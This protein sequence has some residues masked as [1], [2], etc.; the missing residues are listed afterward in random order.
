MNQPCCC[1]RSN[2]SFICFHL[3]VKLTRENNDFKGTNSN[4]QKLVV[5]LEKDLHK[6]A[7]NQDTGAKQ[8]IASQATVLNLESSKKEGTCILYL[9]Y[10]VVNLYLFYWVRKI[11]LDFYKNKS[12]ITI[13]ERSGTLT[14]I[15]KFSTN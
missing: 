5:E 7:R 13:L 8:T 11:F 3:F 14:L 1:I 4:L 9:F 2:I 10:S 15:L 12:W 6:L